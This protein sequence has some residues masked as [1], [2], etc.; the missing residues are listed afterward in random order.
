MKIVSVGTTYRIYGDDLKTYD[1]LPAGTYKAEFHPRS[2]FFLERIENFVSKEE[3]IYGSHQEKIDK[4]LKSYN[5]FDRSLG[6]ILSGHKG[7]GKSMFVQL[8]GERVVEDLDIP[9]IMVPKAYPGIADFIESIDQECLV[10]F[11]EFEKMFNPRNEEAE[12]QDSLLGLF[13]GTSQKKRMYAITVNDLHKV[14]SFMLSRPG[15]FH[16]HIRFD[17]PSSAEVEIY[18]RDKVDE[19]YHGEIKHVVS[20][21]NRVK[22]NYDSLRAIAFELNEGYTFRSSIGDLNILTTETQRYDVKVTLN[23]GR[24]IDFK[25]RN[26]SLFSEEIRLDKYIDRDDYLVITFDPGNIVEGTNCM[27]LE[28]EY[29]QTELQ[30][31]SEDVAQVTVE[32]VVITHVREVGVNYNLA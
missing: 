13:D 21:A 1:K 27:T 12:K 25:D 14:N 20:F 19:Q 3:K 26:L 16:Y 8:I 10:V 30:S 18:L 23:G 11:D 17:Y 6:I 32:S 24:V 2:G 22:L 7:M 31:D 4:V 29:V 5:K 15:R 28:G 9:V